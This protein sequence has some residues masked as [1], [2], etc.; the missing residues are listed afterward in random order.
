MGIT[1]RYANI[2][3]LDEGIRMVLITPDQKD[4]MVLYLSVDE[5]IELRSD[6]IDLIDKAWATMVSDA[7]AEI[8]VLDEQIAR[9]TTGQENSGV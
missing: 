4:H 7:D 8:L 2:I 3:H 6:L 5:A 9:L 1:V